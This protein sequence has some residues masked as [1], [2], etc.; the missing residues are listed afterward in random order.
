MH[1]LFDDPL[2][3]SPPTRQ[4]SALAI[5]AEQFGMSIA[6]LRQHIAMGH[7]TLPA[8]PAI[9]STGAIQEADSLNAC[10]AQPT[11]RNMPTTLTIDSAIAIVVDLDLHMIDAPVARTANGFLV[12]QTPP[13]HLGDLEPPPPRSFA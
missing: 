9:D 4:T 12:F 8:G 1:S 3:G 6:A 7:I 10:P 2:A 13:E 11:Y 5:Y